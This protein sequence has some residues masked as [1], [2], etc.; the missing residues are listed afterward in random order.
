MLHARS[1]CPVDVHV[2]WPAWANSGTR[3]APHQRWPG[4][5]KMWKVWKHEKPIKNNEKSKLWCESLWKP[6]QITNISPHSLYFIGFHMFYK[7]ALTF[8]AF[9]SAFHAF[10]TFHTFPWPGQRWWGTSL[11]PLLAQAWTSTWTN[12]WIEGRMIKGPC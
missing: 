11:V 8:H 3:E 4:Q 10:H 1:L 12:N 6:M 9:R 7:T 5:G 2:A